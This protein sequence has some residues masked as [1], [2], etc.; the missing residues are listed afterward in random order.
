[1]KAFPM[2]IKTTGRRVVVVGGGEQAAQK[3]RLIRKTDAEIVIVAAALDDELQGIVKSGKA[4]HF[5]GVL[6]SGVFEDAAMAFVATGCS[7]IDVSAHALA[8]AARC[9]VNVVDRP[10]LCDITTPALVDRDP[11]VIAIGTEGTGPVLARQIKT[12]FEQILPQNLG[13]LAEIAG[14]LRAAVAANVPRKRRKEFWRWVF[15]GEPMAKW[16]RGAETHAARLVK[17]ALE[18]GSAPDDAGAGFASF[19]TVPKG[20]VDL[21]TLRAM[22]RLQEAETIY[23]EGQCRDDVLELARRDAER[24]VLNAGH[25]CDPWQIQATAM[26]LAN[27]VRSGKRI[28]HLCD[29]QSTSASSSDRKVKFLARLGL[30]V[31]QIPHCQARAIK[32]GA[33]PVQQALN[34]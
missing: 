1:M 6:T 28:V 2:F 23:I 17:A 8:K 13:G 11:I 19:I 14:S 21:I 29:D 34:S 4:R 33:Q 30:E 31:E 27:A 32:S 25:E 15:A 26:T 12:K 3:V 10:H 24:V 22:R 5:K 18:Q 9:P 7:A 20:E 16:A